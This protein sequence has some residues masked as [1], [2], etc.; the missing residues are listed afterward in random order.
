MKRYNLCNISED[1]KVI[2]DVYGDWV[3]YE[4]VEAILKKLDKY[5]TS[6]NEV[7]VERATILSKTY[8]EIRNSF[9]K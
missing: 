6:C 3:R 9:L 7:P 2:P 1:A 4:D 5:F 8:W